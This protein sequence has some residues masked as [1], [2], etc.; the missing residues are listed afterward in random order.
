MQPANIKPSDSEEVVKLKF[1]V[2]RLEA[3]S[4]MREKRLSL[5]SQDKRRLKKKL[6]QMKWLIRHLINNESINKHIKTHKGLQSKLLQ[7]L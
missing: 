6:M 2:Q 3:I 7:C 1:K 4:E 5:M